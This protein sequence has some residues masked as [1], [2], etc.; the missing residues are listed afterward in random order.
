[1]T[2][3]CPRCGGSDLWQDM[4]DVGVGVIFG[5]KGCPDCGW[6]ELE[7]YDLELGGGIQGDGSYVD[8]YGGLYPK[9]NPVAQAMRLAE[10]EG[11]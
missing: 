5:P 6:S 1:M 7:E 11:K 8:Q 4:V 9:G 3:K 2:E 10:K